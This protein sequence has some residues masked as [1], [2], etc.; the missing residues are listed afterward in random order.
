MSIGKYMY[1][2]PLVAAAICLLLLLVLVRSQSL[3]KDL[4]NERSL[5]S[6][7]VSRSGGLAL[8]CAI[9]LTGL[10]FI[11]GVG[12]W[13]S[14]VAALALVS[15]ADDWHSLPVTLRLAAHVLAALALVHYMMPDLPPPLAALLVLVIVWSTNLYNFMDGSD[16][17]AGGMTVIG[18]GIY[19]VAGWTSGEGTLTWFAASVSAAA[20]IFLLF[21]F[22]PARIFMGDVGS[23]PLGFLAAAMGI[24]GWH[25]A[26][27]PAWFP[28]LTFSPFIVDATFT[29]AQR[30]ARGERFWQAHR[31]HYYQRLV[32]MGLGHRSTALAEYA[33]M[34]STGISAL[35]LLRAPAL[36][37]QLLLGFWA[38][39]YLAL[40]AVV[41][42]K[43][44]SHMASKEDD[45]V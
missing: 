8:V 27:W 45:S 12:T 20:A 28:L 38:A 16:G 22:H 15:F 24:Y 29:L 30:A 17:L 19:A 26:I 39:I 1:F 9:M 4:P 2:A 21:N 3:P 10:L 5:H 41:N 6:A 11:Y 31:E 18:F 42:R 7:P 13:L 37:Q 32:R 34:A 35:F 43:W 33:L 23:I 44:A 36:A 25:S 40:A 14:L